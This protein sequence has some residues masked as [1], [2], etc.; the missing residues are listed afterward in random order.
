MSDIERD[1]DLNELSDELIPNLSLPFQEGYKLNLE[2]EEIIFSPH[3]IGDLVVVSGK[4]LAADPLVLMTVR[5]FDLS[6]EPG[7]Y[8][9]SLSVAR[10]IS[11]LGYEE[12]I[13][14]AMIGIQASPV[15]DWKIATGPTF[16]Y[17]YGSHGECIYGV[18]SATGSFMDVEAEQ[19][20]LDTELDEPEEAT[21][22]YKLTEL[23]DHSNQQYGAWANLCVSQESGANV[24]AFTSGWG[25][26]AYASYFGY[27]REGK[28][29]R[30]VTD[31]QVF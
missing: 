8:P 22:S 16:G 11:R 2:A 14:Y 15:T 7:T 24:I 27:D 18:D 13:A 26:G 20:L 25:D 6:I 23:L 4:I 31:F 19:I 28:V 29:S 21:F 5:P 12:R 1:N 10:F 17:E 9:I 30:I 3:Y